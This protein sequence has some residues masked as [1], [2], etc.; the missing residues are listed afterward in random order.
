MERDEEHMSAERCRCVVC[1]WVTW[2]PWRPELVLCRTR[3]LPPDGPPSPHAP[4]ELEAGPRAA[5]TGT[6]APRA[7]ER[8]NDPAAA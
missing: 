2:E 4:G 1:G 7:P 3:Q 8:V 5:A 6:F